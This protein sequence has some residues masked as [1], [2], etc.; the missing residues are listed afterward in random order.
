MRQQI[1]ESIKGERNQDLLMIVNESA[2][3]SGERMVGHVLK[4]LCE[5]PS[6]TNSSRLMGRATTNKIVVF[7]GGDEF[8][9]QIVD[10]LIEQANGF[11]LHG[12]PVAHP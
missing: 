7:E 9:G 12:T 3:R 1:P 4:V 5:G 6:K 10:V 2:R 8:V 11:S